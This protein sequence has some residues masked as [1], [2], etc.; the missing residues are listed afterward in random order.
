VHAPRTGR[1]AALPL[2]ERAPK[3]CISLDL[4][5]DAQV[6]DEVVGPEAVFASVL[7]EVTLVAKDLRTARALTAEVLRD[8][9]VITA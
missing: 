8:P 3:G 6:G 9:P 2:P 5:V 7:V 1:L 4:D